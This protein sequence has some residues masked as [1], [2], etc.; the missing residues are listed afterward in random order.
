MISKKKNLCNVMF[1]SDP[2]P[3]IAMHW[4][5]LS[6]TNSV[7]FSRLDWCDPGVW[8]LHLKTCWR[9]YCC[10]CWCWETCWWQ[11]GAVSEVEVCSDFEHKVWS[12]FWVQERFLEREFCQYF[13]AD[14]WLRLWS[15]LLVEILKLGLVKIL[16]LSLVKMLRLGWDSEDKVCVRTCD[17]T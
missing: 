1:F 5:P 12:R 17:M 4:L 3:I 16:K 6:L 13:A 2:V 11:F 8:R 9:S 14:A 10:W 7:L 15:L